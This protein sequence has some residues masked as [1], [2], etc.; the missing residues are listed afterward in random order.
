MYQNAMRVNVEF[1]KSSKGFGTRII[2][3][4]YG[5]QAVPPQLYGRI[6]PNMWAAFINECSGLAQHHPYVVKPSGKQVGSWALCFSIAA[7]IGCA[8]INPDGG[9]YMQWTAAVAQMLDRWRPA[10]RQAGI[11]LSL[12]QTREYWIQLDVVGPPQ[13]PPLPYTGQEQ[14][15]EGYEPPQPVQHATNYPQLQQQQQQP[16]HY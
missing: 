7:V 9:D 3:L 5:P 11:E 13:G 8:A 2:K 4:N 6:D 12:Q 1:L 10:F 14:K 16:Q 15:K